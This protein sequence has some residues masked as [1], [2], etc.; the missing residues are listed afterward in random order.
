MNIE[1]LQVATHVA[2]LSLESRTPLEH[3]L[4]HVLNMY[5]IRSTVPVQYRAIEVDGSIYMHLVD[6][7]RPG[8]RTA[9]YLVTEVFEVGD[10]SALDVATEVI[11]WLHSYADLYN[12]IL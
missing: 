8:D 4:V 12:H 6:P 9:P 10:R 1:A 3:G 2:R 5:P 7:A 11:S